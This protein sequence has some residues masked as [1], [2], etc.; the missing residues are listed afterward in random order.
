MTWFTEKYDDDV[1]IS[2]KIDKHLCHKK[3]NFKL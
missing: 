3:S 2:Y 1:K